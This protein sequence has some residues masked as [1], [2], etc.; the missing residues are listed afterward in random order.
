MQKILCAILL[1]TNYSKDGDTHHSIDVTQYPEISHYISICSISH[2]QTS[3]R[4]F[5]VLLTWFL[6][7]IT[8]LL[9]M[10][11]L[12]CCT[13]TTVLAISHSSSSS[14]WPHSKSYQD[15]LLMS[16]HQSAPDACMVPWQD[17]HGVPS[18]NETTANLNKL[19]NQA[20]V[21]QLTN[22]RAPHQDLFCSW[23]ED[24]PSSATMQHCLHQPLQWIKLHLHA[25]T[26][27]IQQNTQ[28]QECIW[29]ICTMPLC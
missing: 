13:G 10:T 19:Q 9:L 17:I 23:N 5:Q 27:N 6:M 25:E 12:N 16:S 21:F 2:N 26:T 3:M 15:E 11:K 29:S 18:P 24:L 14:C 22:L 8:L 4:L 1:T 28:S 7:M 20:N